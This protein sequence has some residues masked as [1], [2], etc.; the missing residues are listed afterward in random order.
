MVYAICYCPLS[1]L[2]DL[3]GLKVAGEPVLNVCIW[4][5]GVCAGAQVRWRGEAGTERPSELLSPAPAFFFFNF[6]DSKTL[7]EN[8]R[9]RL[10]AKME[11]DGDFVGWALDILSPNLIS[12]SMLGR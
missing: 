7:T 9:E 4:G 3:E 5:S 2:T 12:T 11:E 1:R 8:E 6:S 10:F